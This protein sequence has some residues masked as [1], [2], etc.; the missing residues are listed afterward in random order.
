M[1]LR[2]DRA[3]RLGHTG[4]TRVRGGAFLMGSNDHYPEERPV[5][6]AAVGDFWMDAHPVT[7]AEFA[8]FVAATGYRTLAETPP[9][10]RDYPGMP[11]HLA[12]PGSAVFTPTAGPVDLDDPSAWWR[13][14]LGAD[15][16]HPAGPGSTIDGI[17]DHPVV[18]VACADAEAYARWAGKALPTEAEW[19]YAAR[20][21][22]ESL[23]FAW[24]ET[25][26]PGGRLMANYWQGDFPWRNTEEDGYARTSPVG[27]FP[28]NGF[29]LHD[30][31]G[32]VWEW[33]ADWYSD[34]PASPGRACCGPPLARAATAQ[35]SLD[36]GAPGT[37]V[38]RRVLK[39]GSHLCA[40]SYCRRYRPAARHPQPV[41]S[42]TSHI[43]FRCVVREDAGD[44]DAAQAAAL[45]SRAAGGSPA[46][47]AAAGVVS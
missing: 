32:N 30:M 24:G 38:P 26:A 2:Q 9:D 39:G 17:P 44:R 28:P 46:H 43:G 8:A 36:P 23:P 11:A 7:N 41:D 22:L 47:A 31:I 25:L 35:E 13:F 6:Q 3:R 21:G 15:W 5:R 1:T 18:Q 42:P 14:V 4:M 16:R 27:A 33:T 34:D 20:G 29:G 40:A 19:E 37:P 12:R 45:P 10:P